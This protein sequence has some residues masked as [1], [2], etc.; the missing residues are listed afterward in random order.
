MV[1]SLQGSRITVYGSYFE[2]VVVVPI[3]GQHIARGYGED[4]FYY[5][6]VAVSWLRS[7]F[8]DCYTYESGV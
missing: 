4:S 7:V 6:M 5:R 2:P 1:H 3:K 8:Q